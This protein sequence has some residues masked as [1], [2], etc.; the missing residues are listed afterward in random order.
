[1]VSDPES[2]P[3]SLGCAFCLCR[4]AGGSGLEA[5][6]DSCPVCAHPS[7]RLGHSW[8]G[9][10]TETPRSGHGLGVGPGTAA[11][12][13]HPVV[14][15]PLPAPWGRAVMEPGRVSPCLHQQSPQPLSAAVKILDGIRVRHQPLDESELRILEVHVL[16][17][18]VVGCLLES[19]ATHRP[20]KARPHLASPPLQARGDTVFL[21]TCRSVSRG[22]SESSFAWRRQQLWE[23]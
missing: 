3:G 23:P 22:S 4:T 19:P 2:S 12:R 9:S 15:H 10:P 11:A 16:E 14:S 8:A 1:M 20:C 18:G 6:G 5:L 7:P 17:R 13:L 21:S